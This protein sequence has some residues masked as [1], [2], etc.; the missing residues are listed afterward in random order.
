MHG[1]TREV[2]TLVRA[3]RDR[4]AGDAP[5]TPL[6]AAYCDLL[7]EVQSRGRLR[8]RVVNDIVAGASAGG[9]NGVFLARALITGQSLEPLTRLWLDGADVDTLLSADARPDRPLHQAVGRTDRL[10]RRPAERRGRPRDVGRGE[11]GGGRQA[12]AAGARAMVLSP[13]RGRH[14][15]QPDPGRAGRHGDRAGRAAPA[16]AGSAAGPVRHRDRFPRPS[17]AAVPP[18][19]ALRGGAGA[20][21]GVRLPRLRRPA[22]RLGRGAGARGP[23]HGELSGR[24][25]ARNGG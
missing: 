11:G 19:A 6:A 9:L 21:S 2:W 10:V 5:A 7:D 4:E 12:V 13:V 3:S 8:L 24:L 1:I 20:S 16:A 18:L 22:A 25:S 23:R 17:A 14:L 15:H